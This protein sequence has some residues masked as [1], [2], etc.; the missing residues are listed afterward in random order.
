MQ[1][2]LNY[3][4]EATRNVSKIA[5]PFLKRN[6]LNYFQFGRCYADGSHLPLVTNADFLSAR[7]SANNGV[8]SAINEHQVD[9]HTF[10]FLWNESLALEDTNQ[11]REFDL[12]NGICFVERHTDFYDLIAF[13]APRSEKNINNFYL[14]NIGSLKRFIREFK[15]Q[16]EELI[17]QAESY[18]LHLPQHLQ[19]QNKEKMLWK[20]NKSISIAAH[21]S[22][23][24]LSL[25]E[26]ECLELV[27]NGMVLR[28]IA[29]K[30][31]ISTRTVETYLDRVK[32]KLGLSKKS[33]LAAVFHDTRL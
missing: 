2:N 14:N 6:L 18:R 10:I 12:D 29:E 15:D 22:N 26:Y 21:G 24:R 13:A 3:F 5:E 28:E 19:D 25:K 30:M 33:E 7:L 4:Y 9:A 31:N 8:R 32:S 17:E 23:A 16:G 27:A 1:K 20:K 11:A